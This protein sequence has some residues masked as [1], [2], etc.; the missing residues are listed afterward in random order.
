MRNSAIWCVNLF[1]CFDV[2]IDNIKV[3]G[4]WR[5]NTDGIDV[6]NSQN[7]TIRNSFVHSFDDTITIKAIDRDVETNNENMLI[8]NCVLWC[9]W[10]KTLEL[11]FETACRE[12]KNI[13]FRNCDILR[14]GNTALDIQNGDCAEISD[15]LYE[16]I[17]IEYNSFDNVPVMQENDESVYDGYG[18]IMIP[19]FIQFAN[20][21]FRNEF[22]CDDI[23]GIPL[24]M[25]PLDLTGIQKYTIHDITVKNINIYFDEEIPVNG[26]KYPIPLEITSMFDDVK[27]YNINIS[28]VKINGKA[29]GAENFEIKTEDVNNFMFEKNE[30]NFAQMD[31]NT[32]KATNQL[33]E[34]EYIRFE[35]PEGKGMR[36]LFAGNSITL[37][38]V[39]ED[40]GWFNEWGM[41]AS[42]KEKDYVH[43]A[44]SGIQK[45]NPDAVFCISQV[46]RWETS[47]KNPEE[48]YPLYEASRNFDADVIVARFV[49]NCSGKDFDEA[50]FEKNYEEFLKFL[51][52]SGKAKYIIT[53][54]FWKHPGDEAIKR[55]AQ[56]LNAPCIYLGD[57]GEMDEMKAV[58]LFEHSGVAAHPGDKG[59]SEI[60]KLILEN[61]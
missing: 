5:Y 27:H 39:K 58:G 17:N 35:N 37:H 19:H 13:T 2:D 21:R 40:I 38:G 9:D 4:Q 55:V 43:V 22:Y 28:D 6:V 7:I 46:A 16:N 45:E 32:V 10:G 49:E 52:P 36:V 54:G 1:H 34:S 47:Y 53:T 15:I 23:W 8:D 42:A 18:R 24:E 12:Y 48:I 3:F 57:L 30:N 59:M 14:A 60:A 61:M 20:Y 51:S 50:V 33:K 11:G 26:D 56:K 25:A 41:A 29:V 44:M 31:K